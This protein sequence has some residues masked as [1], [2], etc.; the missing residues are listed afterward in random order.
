MFTIFSTREVVAAIYILL[1]ICFLIWNKQTRKSVMRVIKC[2]CTIKL[3]IPF[4]IFLIYTIVIIYFATLLP[5]WDAIFLKDI[6]IWFLFIGVPFCYNAVSK[7]EKEH[8]FTKLLKDNI[9]FIAVLEF[10]VGTFTFYF[11]IELLLQPILAFIILLQTI[12]GTKEKWKA[13]KKFLDIVVAFVGFMILFFTIRAAL[14]KYETINPVNTIVSFCI[15]IVFS[16]LFIPCAYFLALI[17]KYEI[18]YMRMGFKEPKDRKIKFKRHMKVFLTCGLNY[19][20]VCRFHNEYIKRLY[21][22]MKDEEFKQVLSDFKKAS[23]TS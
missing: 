20:K 11:W 7:A 18:V 17:A 14:G 1:I 16:V 13:T 6:I 21:I 10:L 23:K 22:M 2:A 8:Y 3:I 15:P 19:R 12:S 5:F 4:V 9:K